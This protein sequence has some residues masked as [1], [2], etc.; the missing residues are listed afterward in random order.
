MEYMARDLITGVRDL[1]SDVTGYARAPIV[2]VQVIR[3]Q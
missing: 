2:T 3:Q 1:F